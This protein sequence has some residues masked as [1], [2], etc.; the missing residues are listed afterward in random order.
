[1]HPSWLCDECVGAWPD[2]AIERRAADGTAR[3][4]PP[5]VCDD[6]YT[7]G[8]CPR[9]GGIGLRTPVPVRDMIRTL[10]HLKIPPTG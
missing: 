4:W 2:L 3:P 9:C 5:C 8:R 10:V 7:D 1:M 6:R